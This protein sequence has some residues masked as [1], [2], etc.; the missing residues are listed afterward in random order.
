MNLFYIPE[1]FD[2]GFIDQY[3]SCDSDFC[4]G[5]LCIFKAENLGIKDLDDDDAV[6][7]HGAGTGVDGSAV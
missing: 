4:I 1:K 3:G 2:S 6:H 5:R 7:D